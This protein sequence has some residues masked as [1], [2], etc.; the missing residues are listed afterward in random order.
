MP[1]YI[2]C[3][4][5]I[6]LFKHFHLRCLSLAPCVKDL[7]LELSR[8]RDVFVAQMYFCYV[9][10]L[11]LFWPKTP[12]L[13]NPCIFPGIYLDRVMHFILLANI[14]SPKNKFLPWDIFTFVSHISRI[15][16]S[17]GDQELLV[18]DVS[19]TKRRTPGRTA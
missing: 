7:E 6:C 19:L 5:A 16:S 15:F 13:S 8:L 3:A 4:P 12:P 1:A 18:Q 9:A 2:S 14:S 17:R 11:A 10:P